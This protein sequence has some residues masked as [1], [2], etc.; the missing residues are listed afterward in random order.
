MLRPTLASLR[1]RPLRA[2]LTALS[3]VL[4][5]AMISGTFVLTH[6]IDR[7]FTAIFEA[8]NAKNDV[9][10]ELRTVSDS[11][12]GFPPALPGLG[13]QQG[14]ARA[15]GRRG[16]RRDRRPGLARALRAG[17][18]EERRLDRWRPAARVLEPAGALPHRRLRRTGA[19]PKRTGEIALLKDTASKAKAVIGT[20]L[21]L[22]T[23]D[24]LKQL[25]VVGIYKLGSDVP[26]SAVRS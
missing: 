25:R 6:Q 18:A 19:A 21:G 4:G 16:E 23:L 20:R 13:A 8:A 1:A 14:R 26:R 3:I 11:N 9:T 5:V 12:N 17:Q 24:G 10:I 2:I 22:V 15:R 7:A